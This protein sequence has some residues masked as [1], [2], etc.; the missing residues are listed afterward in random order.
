[1]QI[2]NPLVNLDIP[3]TWEN[4]QSFCDWWIAAKMPLVF[5]H[6]TEIF[7]SD[8]ATAVCLFKK[9]RFQVELYLIHPQPSVQA[10]EHPDVEV[11]KIRTVAPGGPTATGTLHSG[12]SHGASL[13]LEAE[14]SGFPVFAVQHWLTREP[15][16]IAS[17]WKGPTAG[18][19][20]EA[21]IRRFN[22]DAYVVENYA[23]IT[24]KTIDTI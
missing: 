4:V 9:G 16:T 15:T 7:M 11:I 23:D 17:M 1:M 24:R 14:A 19:K 22:P 5:P 12:E 20:H 18:P 10:H 2:V 21:L 13:K 8:D 6:N 3:D